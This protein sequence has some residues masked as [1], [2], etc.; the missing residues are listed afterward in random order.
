MELPRQV[1]LLPVVEKFQEVVVSKLKAEKAFCLANRRSTKTASTSRK[2]K[3]LYQIR[4]META[5]VIST[6]VVEAFRVCPV[7]I[8][9]EWVH[10]DRACPSINHNS[11]SMVV[12]VVALAVESAMEIHIAWDIKRTAKEHKEASVAQE[13]EFKVTKDLKQWDQ[14]VLTS[15]YLQFRTKW[16]WEA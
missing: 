15:N 16:Q 7:L 10:K 14:E 1:E 12:S 2:R 3:R 13:V 4:C 9:E 5:I 11:I 6:R 8:L